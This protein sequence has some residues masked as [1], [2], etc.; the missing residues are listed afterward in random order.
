MSD[1]L[2]DLLLSLIVY[3]SRFIRA[4]YRDWSQ[5]SLVHLARGFSVIW[6][7]ICIHAAMVLDSV[8]IVSVM[9]PRWMCAEMLGSPTFLFHDVRFLVTWTWIAIVRFAT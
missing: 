8:R 9:R 6:K 3:W 1:M 7:E 4:R 5:G 2:L